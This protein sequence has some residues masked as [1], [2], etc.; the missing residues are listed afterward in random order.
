MNRHTKTAIVSLA[1]FAAMLLVVMLAPVGFVSWS[2]GQTVDLLSEGESGPLIEVSEARTYPASGSILLTT[3]NQTR[4]DS[5]LRFPQAVMAYLLGAHD[6]FPR[7]DIYPTGLGAGEA[8]AQELELM[9]QAKT[10]AAVAAVREAGLTV[11]EAP[12]V[13]RV[14][15]SGPSNGILQTGDI[16]LAIDN[17]PVSSVDDAV[18]RVRQKPVG[19]VV[20]VSIERQGRTEPPITIQTVPSSNDGRVPTIGVTLASEFFF[21]PQVTYRID[22]AIG[23][24]SAGLALALAIY[25]RLTEPDLTG[26]LTV[27]ATGVIDARG[28]VGA[29]GGID[30]KVAAALARGAQ[31]FLL[32][33]TNCS[34]LSEIPSDIRLVPVTSLS[35]AVTIMEILTRPGSGTPLPS[36]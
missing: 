27:A 25:D 13:T 4:A 21:A 12:K 17:V 26:G 36:C 5:A 15:V 20:V 34:D 3:V 9:V 7:Q 28:R 22:P 1:V 14:R 23:G 11:R 29:I 8:T 33:A 6:V 2:P 31:V 35:T 19:D 10:Q 30:Q 32:P 16:I 24:D 18:D